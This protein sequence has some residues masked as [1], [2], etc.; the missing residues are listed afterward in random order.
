MRITK[1]SVCYKITL[2]FWRD[3]NNFWT[4]NH[5]NFSVMFTTENEIIRWS[6]RQIYRL[7]DTFRTFKLLSKNPSFCSFLS[8]GHMKLI[9]P[10]LWKGER[11]TSCTEADSHGLEWCST[12]T[13]V[14]DNHLTGYWGNCDSLENELAQ[15]LLIRVANVVA[16]HEKLLTQWRY[17]YKWVNNANI[18]LISTTSN[19]LQS[20]AVCKN[21]SSKSW[22]FWFSRWNIWK[23]C[24]NWMLG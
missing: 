1:F 19:Y 10:T 17:M 5:C 4:I 9:N 23:I 11:Y 6:W 2:L 14:L 7:L 13:D 22:L 21:L 16:H 12:L 3:W 15:V 24:V 20:S 18:L 8:Y